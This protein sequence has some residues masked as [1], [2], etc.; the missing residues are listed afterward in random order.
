[1]SS[2]TG[3][4]EKVSVKNG[5]ILVDG[6]WY[7][8]WQGQETTRKGVVPGTHVAF[9]WTP[10]K[11]GKGF[12]NIKTLT[13]TGAPV[14]ST[15][16]VAVPAPGAP[17]NW[18]P[19]NNLGVELGH[20]SKLAMDLCLAK[21]EKADIGTPEFYKEWIQHTDKIYRAMGSLREAKASP[22]TATAVAAAP[23]KAK[24]PILA[25]ADEEPF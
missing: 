17:T 14:I 1:M 10:D 15:G 5:S 23:A 7:S 20:A 11:A 6:E 18:K 19:Q 22:A 16:G 13:V 2:V 4:V 21:S 25:S 12:R 8:S 9:T 3:V 24:E